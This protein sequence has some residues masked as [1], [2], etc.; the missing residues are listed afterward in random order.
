M[1]KHRWYRWLHVDKSKPHVA[2]KVI[3]SGELAAETPEQAMQK[4]DAFIS[5]DWHQE[6]IDWSDKDYYYGDWVK[7]RNGSISMRD[8]EHVKILMPIEEARQRERRKSRHHF[9]HA[10]RA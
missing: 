4:I 9:Q 7:A 5:N 6:W 2:A 3:A 1:A 10:A 8:N